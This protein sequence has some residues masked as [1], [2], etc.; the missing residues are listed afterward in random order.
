MYIFTISIYL[1]AVKD[2]SLKGCQCHNRTFENSCRPQYIQVQGCGPGTSSSDHIC[3]T[4]VDEADLNEIVNFSDEDPKLGVGEEGTVRESHTGQNK[5]DNRETEQNKGDNR[6]TE[7][8]KGD[9]SETEKNTADNRE[10]QQTKGDDG[11]N[12]Q[13][14]GDDGKT[15]SNVLLDKHG[16]PRRMMGKFRR[17][18]RHGK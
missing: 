11:K 13:N 6:E 7:Q 18:P 2:Q 8:N 3:C 17:R 5:E 16:K 1:S 10:T 15:K 4:D 9:N 12:D 14:K